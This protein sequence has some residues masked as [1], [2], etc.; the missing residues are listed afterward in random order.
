MICN[1]KERRG[2]G[3]ESGDAEGGQILTRSSDSEREWPF[4]C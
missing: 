3:S 2:D 1:E 4:A